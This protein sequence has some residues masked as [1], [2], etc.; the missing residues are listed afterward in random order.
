MLGRELRSGAPPSSWAQISTDANPPS[1][2]M[3][4]GHLLDRYE[5]DPT[6]KAE[7][8]DEFVLFLGR[9]YDNFKLNVEWFLT[10]QSSEVVADTFRWRGRTPEYCLASGMDDYPRAPILT[11]NEAHVDLQTWMIVSTNVLSRVATILEKTEDAK[12]YADKTATYKQ[13]LHDNF[14]DESRQMFD[15]FYLDDDN[16]KQFE[17]HTGYLNFWPFFLDAID[18]SDAKFETTVRKLI[19]PATGLWSDYGI[20]SLSN[21]D[22]YY[23]L[24]DNY[25]TSPIWMNINFLITTALHK[26]GADESI[27]STLRTDIATAYS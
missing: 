4:L 25:W 15:D 13:V 14:W 6:L 27:E 8:Y 9:I 10:T 11:E 21:T 23:K 7:S 24:G 12:Y 26:Y 17:G 22:P 20:R 3:L 5:A 2:H 18:T 19:D 1:Q 16:V